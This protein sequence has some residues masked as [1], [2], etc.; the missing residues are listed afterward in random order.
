MDRN[1]ETCFFMQADL[2][3]DLHS[4]SRISSLEPPQPIR[5]LQTS[6]PTSVCLQQSDGFVEFSL[7]KTILLKVAQGHSRVPLN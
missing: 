7:N 3:A 5:R 4:G 6:S 1:I 2:Q